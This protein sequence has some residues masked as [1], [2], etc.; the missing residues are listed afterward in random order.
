M[1]KTMLNEISFASFLD[2]I[3]LNEKAKGIILSSPL[4]QDEISR[5]YEAIINGEDV[6]DAL[7]ALSL[8]AS[9]AYEITFPEYRKRDI[10]VDIAIATLSDIARWEEE[11]ERTHEG[12]PGL[13]PGLSEIRWLNYH[14]QLQL[15]ALGSL[16]YQLLPE[17]DGIFTLNLHI[18]K[19]SDISLPSVLSSF[20]KTRQ[21]FKKDKI[22][23]KCFS[24]LLSD[25]L[26][27]LLDDSSRIK[28]F[29]SL[30]T[31]VS[32]DYGRRQAEERIFGHLE[33]NPENYEVETSLAA[34]AREYLIKGGKLPVTS[35]FLI[36]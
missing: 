16:Q 27:S 21:F 15:F 32:S 36:I 19:D 17:E 29:S 2:Q 18:P 26:S 23:I 5:G 12:R 9:A 7:R 11:Y 3:N 13:Q 31:K 30:F 34:K 4:T 33:D 6:T 20:E 22:K 10:S 24:W 14:L 8:V 28:A 25:E 1:D 35:G